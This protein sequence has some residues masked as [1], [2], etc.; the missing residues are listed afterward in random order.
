MGVAAIEPRFRGFSD[1]ALGGYVGGLVARGRVSAE[2]TLRR[3]VRLSTPYE[4][5][6]GEDGS[7]SLSD[8]KGPLA[9]V[10]DD[11][12]RVDTPDPVGL[13]ESRTA[14]R[15]YLGFV[16][17]LIPTCFVCGTDRPEGDGLRIFPGPVVGRDV[18]AA[19]WTPSRS[20]A[21]S[22]GRVRP[23]FVWSSLDCPSIWALVHRSPPDDSTRVVTVRVAVRRLRPVIAERPHVVMGWK[24]GASERGQVAGGAVFD[25]DGQLAA[26]ARHTLVATDWGV[27]LGRELWK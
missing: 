19:P 15:S 11:E 25:E 1:I 14:S 4:L 2:V 5:T 21:E 7:A 27:P 6:E 3:P 23:E 17:H 24:I 26:V 20:L 9:V 12:V 22:D 10:R 8:Q 18:V 16:K 13:E